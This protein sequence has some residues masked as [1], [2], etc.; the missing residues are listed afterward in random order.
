MWMNKT[1]KNEL[2]NEAKN[3]NEKEHWKRITFNGEK[4][5]APGVNWL[6]QTTI[7]QLSS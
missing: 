2:M 5:S 7:Y 3:K 4:T 6:G 1:N